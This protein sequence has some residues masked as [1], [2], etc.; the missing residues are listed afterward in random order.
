MVLAPEEDAYGDFAARYDHF[1]GEFGQYDP[2][3]VE[4]FRQVFERHH[5]QSVLDCACGTGRHLP[6]FHSLCPD[7]IGSDLSPAMLAQ[8]K[9]NL[10]SAGVSVPLVQADYRELPAHFDR[11]FDAIACLTTSIGHMPNER[12]A[13]RALESMYSVLR[14]GGALILTQGTTDR[15][16]RE[17]PRF[18]LAA[19]TPEMTRLFVIDYHDQGAC[20]NVVDVLHERENDR[21]EVWATDYAHMYLHDDYERLLAAAGFQHIAFYG[22]YGLTAY[23]KEASQRLI[24]VAVK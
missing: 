3:E 16:W 19:D 2:A 4:F 10:A 6:L 21:L 22:D 23:D 18:I 20:Y 1:F 17:K 13:L 9:K 8:A 12:E 24:V 11:P 15:Q 5:I 14:E 7:V